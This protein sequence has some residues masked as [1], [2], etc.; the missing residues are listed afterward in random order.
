M[1][2][3][4]PTVLDERAWQE[5][6]DALTRRQ[7]GIGAG[8]AAVAT[9]LSSCSSSDGS[10]TSDDTQ[11]RTV[12]TPLGTYDIPTNLKRVL[13]VDARTDLE[14]A[15]ALEL[16]VFGYNI[17]PA[18]EWVPVDGSAEYL[19]DKPNLEQILGLAPDL[20]ICVNADNE[21]WPAAKLQAIA[22]V[23][24]TESKQTWRENLTR[25]SDW[26]GRT[27]T[28][29]RLITDYDA[30]ITDIRSR[31]ASAIAGKTVASLY[32]SP[33]KATIYIDSLPVSEET[34]KKNRQPTDMTLADIGGRTLNTTGF[35]NQ[36][37]LSIEE[38]D[39]LRDCDAFMLSVTDSS[40][41]TFDQLSDNKLW[42]RLPAVQAGN[43]TVLRG[44][45]YY[46][47][48]YTTMYVAKGW[49]DLYSTLD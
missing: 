7:F 33:D 41:T 24:T 28:M 5:L 23:L 42:Q 10:G 47:S 11:M 2:T 31:H 40:D 39:R 34:G 37:R 20:I 38:M 6:V 1:L 49:D 21:Y 27:P 9:I 46:G 45:T 32:Y 36:G 43:V 8:M 26:L 13:A 12:T 30:L 4:T 19:S 18:T 17:S 25:L 3:T 48:I 14:L 15:I 16:P 44:S 22:P 35:D 29:D